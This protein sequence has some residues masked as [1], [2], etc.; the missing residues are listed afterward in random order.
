[1]KKLSQE[2]QQQI[3]DFY[4]RCG[5]QKDIDEG[6]DLI[7]TSPEAAKLYAD[8]E[9][10]LTELDHVKYEA[11]PDNL[12]DL[13]IARLRLAAS[14]SRAPS[15]LEQ[16]L[17]EERQNISISNSESTYQSQTSNNL[18]KKVSLLRP[19]FEVLA[20]AASIA[21]VAGIFFPSM[22]FARDKYRQ[23]ACQNNLRT[24]GAAFSTFAQDNN[25]RLSDVRIKP[26]SPW[27][28]IGYQGPES[29]SNTRYPFIL[30]KEGYA[31]SKAFVCKGYKNA[32]VLNAQPTD[33]KQ[34]HDFPSRH[35]ITYSFTLFCDK[36]SNILQR[37]RRIIASD[38]NPVFV[39][40][41]D[42]LP[43]QKNVYS[44]M[45]QFDRLKLNEQL[46]QSLSASH[47]QRGQNILFCDGSVEYIKDRV[48][49]GD[50]MFTL[51]GVNEYTGLER[52]ASEND[53]FLA[54]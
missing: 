40:V 1:M 47:R 21:I 2:H 28:K 14:G 3:L 20:A 51:E 12:V 24:V 13:T 46:M 43:C 48:I 45:T 25:D 31:D 27:W 6:R 18:P 19:V 49:N 30:V 22:G 26:G 38:I 36:N 39:S 11:C 9:Y 42:K 8:L 53:I 44:R 5:D 41:F 17:E 7:A 54:P 37:R 10:S 50:D 32:E 35:N 52:P 16:L 34:L 33:L 23:V 4:F 15:K 29:Q